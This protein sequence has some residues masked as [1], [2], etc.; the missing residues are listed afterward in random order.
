MS[1]RTTGRPQFRRYRGK[2]FILHAAA[3]E[4]KP[5][6]SRLGQTA[7]LH[8]DLPS[9]ELSFRDCAACLLQD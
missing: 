1:Q 9:Q 7:D 8:T 3:G 5:P 4:R 2:T 6:P